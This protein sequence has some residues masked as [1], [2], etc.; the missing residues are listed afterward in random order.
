M[1]LAM[2]NQMPDTVPVSPDISN[3]IPARL[4]GKPFWDIYLY[5]DPPLWQ[6]YIDAV[7]YFQMDGWYIYGGLRYLLKGDAR[8]LAAK[9]VSRTAERIVVRTTCCTPSGDL[10]WE[11]TYYLDNPPTPTSKWIKDPAR[12]IPIVLKHFFP[13]IVGYDDT[14]VKRR[15]SYLGEKG[16]FGLGIDNLPGFHDLVW[17]F[18]GGL[19]AISY[20]HV[21]YPDLF[22]EL[23]EKQAEYEVRKAELAL[24]VKPD[25]FMIG[26]SGLWTLSSPS[27]FRR[28][29][30]P[31]LQKITRMAK[32]ADIPS[33]LHSCGKARELAGI[34]ANE[35]D[36]SCINPLEV[37]PMGDCDLAEVKRS[38]GD[39]LALMG[40]LH[41]TDVMLRGTPETVEEAALQAI[42]A[43]ASGGGFILSTGDQCGRDTPDENIRSLVRAARRYGKY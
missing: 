28:F 26:A 7:C 36:L 22:A 42:Q 8:S 25:F 17:L 9:T 21:D 2:R 38:L 13:P 30:L 10:F 34:C 39:R 5:D 18:D 37:P 16:A 23:L 40:N 35:T 20:A 6:A 32:E 29:T 43:A 27:I 3:M 33:F 41:T 4:T 1:V 24:E 14:E 15:R 31:T 11:D 12:D 19:E